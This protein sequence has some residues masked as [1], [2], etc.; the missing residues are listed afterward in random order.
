MGR[1]G[2]SNLRPRNTIYPHTPT[3]LAVQARD[4]P[5]SPSQVHTQRL[6]TLL[7][8]VNTNYVKTPIQTRS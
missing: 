7:G 1:V 4:Y 8:K 5:L 6:E 2:G 3:Y